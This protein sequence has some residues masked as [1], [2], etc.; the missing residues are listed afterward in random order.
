MA[1]RVIGGFAATPMVLLLGAWPWQCSV[2]TWL[3]PNREPVPIPAPSVVPRS[4]RPERT[5]ERVTTAPVKSPPQRTVMLPEAV[6]IRALDTMRPSF[7]RCFERARQLDPTIGR[8][9]V[10]LHL[11]VD[12]QGTVVAVTTDTDVRKLSNCLSVIARQMKF[13]AAGQPAVVDVPLMF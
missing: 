6:V 13:G 12:A 5:L 3:V 10:R 9:K 8:L 4:T 7:L 2:A 1:G 11:D